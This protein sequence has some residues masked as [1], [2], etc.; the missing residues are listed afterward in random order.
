MLVSMQ[1]TWERGVTSHSTRPHRQLE[2]P[3]GSPL[4][5]LLDS[6]N[7]SAHISLFR[8]PSLL[9]AMPLPWTEAETLCSTRDHRD[10]R[11]PVS[12]YRIP[13]LKMGQ[14]LPTLLE[15][16]RTDI[17]LGVLLPPNYPS[18]LPSSFLP[19]LS[20]ITAFLATISQYIT[21]AKLP[22]LPQSTLSE[23][24]AP[25]SAK[26]PLHLQATETRRQ[27]RKK[28]PKTKYPSNKDKLESR[29]LDL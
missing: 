13:S 9:T 25:T 3:M 23:V 2:S 21:G 18:L 4:A 26:T 27:E 29:Q 22:V 19:T 10:Y 12:T 8:V 6:P 20:P 28:K 17:N 5:K 14:R 16:L 15:I 11:S 1:Q 24:Q 7:L